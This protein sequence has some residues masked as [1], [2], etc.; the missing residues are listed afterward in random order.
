MASANAAFRRRQLIA[1]I[2]TACRETGI[3]LQR[4]GEIT[5]K[6]TG[7]TELGFCGFAQLR[8]VRAAIMREGGLVP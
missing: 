7:K 1:D 6:L 3:T 2:G 8:Q 5:K 4:R